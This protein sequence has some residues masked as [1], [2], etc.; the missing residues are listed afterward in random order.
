M[1]VDYEVLTGWLHRDYRK[2]GWRMRSW[3]DEDYIQE[4]LCLYLAI[5]KHYSKTRG[6][7][8]PVTEPKH[9]M[10]LFKTSWSNHVHDKSRKEFVTVGDDSLV[11]L[12]AAATVSL[13]D[14]DSIA[15][16]VSGDARALLT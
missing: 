1:H 5:E 13:V 7:R 3:T 16:A 10:A 11:A 6:E 14:V 4:G 8:A 15:G 2:N 9:L 12:E